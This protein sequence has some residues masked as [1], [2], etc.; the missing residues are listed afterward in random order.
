MAA[1]AGTQA[2]RKRGRATRPAVQRRSPRASL[3]RTGR[4]RRT[5][6]WRSRRSRG[7]AVLLRRNAPAERGSA[8]ALR[9]PARWAGRC[10]AGPRH[11][12]PEITDPSVIA[13]SGSSLHTIAPRPVIRSIRCRAP[14]SGSPR[15]SSRPRMSYECRTA[16]A[17]ASGSGRASRRSSTSPP[18]L[19]HTGSTERVMPPST[20]ISDR[21]R[22]Q[23]GRTRAGGSRP[24]RAAELLPHRCHFR[25]R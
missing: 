1:I 4:S 20:R 2:A 16:H 12:A 8:G 25:R 21:S 24:P 6:T 19:E 5:A 15:R 13:T 23:R 17:C 10:A 3:P 9:P 22:R 18:D 11:L 14:R 7:L